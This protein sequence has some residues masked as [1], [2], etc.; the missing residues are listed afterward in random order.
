[1]C[2]F[3]VDCYDSEV[4]KIPPET[5]RLLDYRAPEDVGALSS[6]LISSTKVVQNENMKFRE[7]NA[8]SL[9][10]FQFFS[11]KMV[12]LMLVLKP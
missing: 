4:S 1:M 9:N 12:P 10:G 2:C 11:T 3:A 6:L 5:L 8:R 7:I